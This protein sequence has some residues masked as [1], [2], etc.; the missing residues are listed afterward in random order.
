LLY[1]FFPKETNS[2]GSSLIWTSCSA[3]I[4]LLLGR[5]GNFLNGEL[6]GPPTSGPL[7]FSINGIRRHPTQLY[8]AMLEGAMLFAILYIAVPRMFVYRKAL[9][10]SM[11]LLFYATIRFCLDFIRSEEVV[12]FGLKTS[13]I[14]S[15]W[16]FIGGL[17][18]LFYS[19]RSQAPQ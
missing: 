18:L 17:L 3:P 14:L 4:G 1:T 6:Y 9:L 10:S 19:N 5:I 15:I 16:M 13:Q 8:E 7:A 11:F 2:N 12:G